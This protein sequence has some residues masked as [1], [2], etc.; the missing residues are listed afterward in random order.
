MNIDC[1]LLFPYNAGV[2]LIEVLLCAA[3]TFD[4]DD[5]RAFLRLFVR[6]SIIVI[7]NRLV[8]TTGR[9]LIPIS[10]R[11]NKQSLVRTHQPRRQILP[12]HLRIAP[13]Q[14]VP[15]E[16]KRPELVLRRVKGRR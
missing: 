2:V 7:M 13:R 1:D 14:R 10:A 11:I 6:V 12:L 8:R 15:L 16:L 5:P 3:V 4:E 9:R